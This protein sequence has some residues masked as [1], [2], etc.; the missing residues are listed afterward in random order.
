LFS[1]LWLPDDTQGFIPSAVWAGLAEFRGGVDLIYS[2]APPFSVHLAALILKRLTH[3]RWVAEFR[4]PWT[5]SRMKPWFAKSGLSVRA[6]RWLERKCL[7]QADQVVAVSA[8]IA[9]LLAPKLGPGCGDRLVLARNGIESLTSQRPA[10][11]PGRPF[12][13]VYLGTFYHRRDPMPFLRA[14]ASLK[15]KGLVRPGTVRVE[16]VGLCR[17]YAG[18]S[19]EA[20]VQELGIAEL[21][22]FQDWVSKE[23]AHAL[24]A[25]ADLLLLLAQDQPEQ[26]P[27]KLYDYLGARRPILAFA[28]Q[29]GESASMLREIG[30]HYLVYTDDPLEVE[31]ALEAALTRSPPAGTACTADSKL[32][33]WT[34]ERQMR[35][36]LA[37]IGA[38]EAGGTLHPATPPGVHS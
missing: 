20:A 13:I 30:G 10:P 19:L 23:T 16:L 2:T 31:R 28:D 18:R 32:E 1:F 24:I 12:R 8:G 34:T 14:L 29:E 37:R 36:L 6:E 38:L 7:E 25:N 4:D 26:V 17:T 3:A 27:N 33:E 11:E 5:D 22:T 21:V 9:R 35:H 15:R